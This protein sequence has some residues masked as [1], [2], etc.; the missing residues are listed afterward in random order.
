M[1]KCTV[2]KFEGEVV[3]I[4]NEHVQAARENLYKDNCKRTL[5][6]ETTKGWAKSAWEKDWKPKPAEGDVPAVPPTAKSRKEVKASV[7]SFLDDS[8]TD[9]DEELAYVDEPAGGTSKA[10]TTLDDFSK[11][12]AIPVVTSE[13]KPLD[14]WRVHSTILLDLAK[15]ARQFLAAPANTAALYSLRGGF[16][17]STWLLKFRRAA[18]GPRPR[19]HKGRWHIKYHNTAR[20]GF[21]LTLVTGNGS[22]VDEFVCSICCQL[23]EQPVYTPCTH[24]F[25]KTCLHTW[26]EHKEVCPK[27]NAEL[28]WHQVGNLKTACPLAWRLLGRIRCR[29]PLLQQGC[30]WDGD[31]SELPSHLTSSD[32]HLAAAK[33]AQKEACAE[34]FNQEGNQRFTTRQFKEAIKLYSQAIS[35]NSGEAKYHGNRF[36]TNGCATPLT[37]GP[38]QN[39]VCM[40]VAFKV[41]CLWLSCDLRKSRRSGAAV[42]GTHIPQR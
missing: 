13:V 12:L 28:K 22:Q 33:G 6:V 34:A 32:A 5:T 14:W 3:P 18:Q 35:V 8:D 30:E 19:D 38:A 29:C 31:Y 4:L 16:T 1:H 24:V 9:E 39:G 41:V 21:A 27:C 2:L 36:W 37:R 42:K 7:T 40:C 25:C 23:V 15:M 26:L 17:S 10:P 11:Y 20:M